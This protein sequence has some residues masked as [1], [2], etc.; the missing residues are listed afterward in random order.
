MSLAGDVAPVACSSDER[1]LEEAAQWIVS[2]SADDAAERALARSRFEAWK[3]AD[4]RHAEVA[5][6]ME[7]LVVRMQQVRGGGAVR[8]ARAALDA[9]FAPRARSR[10]VRR[11]ATVLAAICLLLAPVA[12]VVSETYPPAHVLADMRAGTG[13]WKTTTLADGTRITLASASAVNLR[14]D[15]S[16][17]VVELVGGEILVDVARDAIRPFIV[18]TRHGRV[19]ALG[20][21]F[22]VAT[23][24]GGSELSMLESAAAVR[25]VKRSDLPDTVLHAGEQVRFTA[26]GLGEI[27]R[28]DPEGM[29]GAWGHRHLV[30]QAQPLSDVLDQLSRY[31]RGHI[32]FDRDR[33][34]E[35]RISAVLPLDDP[36]RALQLLTNSFPSLRV[37]HITPWLVLVD[38]PAAG[39]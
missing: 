39:S 25:V 37:R 26:D 6:R 23:E 7:Q 8:P 34:Q 24:P 4:P 17:R 36:D 16:R 19:R 1:L 32:H 5:A 9:A 31:R 15:E 3:E 21:R 22:V 12:W 2:L 10:R 27:T 11:A 38:N 18:E 33:L 13:Q 14:F 30:V 35:I 20:T 28:I 29:E